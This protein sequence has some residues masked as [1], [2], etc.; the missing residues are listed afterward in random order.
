MYSKPFM[1]LNFH[2]DFKKISRICLFICRIFSAF[3]ESI[4]Y[5]LIHLT[6]NSFKQFIWWIFI[7]IIISVMTEAWSLFY[8]KWYICLWKIIDYLLNWILHC[9]YRSQTP[10]LL[11]ISCMLP[12]NPNCSWFT[13]YME[14]SKFWILLYSSLVSSEK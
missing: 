5:L 11:F 9:Y 1:K 13:F 8:I 10:K 3:N 12:A 4:N 7:K 6:F 14:L 2:L